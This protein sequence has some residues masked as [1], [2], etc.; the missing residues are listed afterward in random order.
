MDKTRYKDASLGDSTSS[1]N[2]LYLFFFISNYYMEPTEF[3]IQEMVNIGLGE[4]Y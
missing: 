3:E 4:A 1:T 2:W